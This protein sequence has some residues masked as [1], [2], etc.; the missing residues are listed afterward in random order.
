MVHG[1]ESIVDA[2][3]ASVAKEV[4]ELQ[5]QKDDYR[6]ESQ[7]LRG[8]LTKSNIENESLVQEINSL[9]NQELPEIEEK[10]DDS[11]PTRKKKGSKQGDYL[12]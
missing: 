6:K 5:N 7:R 11:R 4:L 12:E 3:I 2:K 10:V 9:K 1:I 8:E